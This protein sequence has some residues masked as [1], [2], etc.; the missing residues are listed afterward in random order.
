VP[1]EA[2]ENKKKK[3]KKKDVWCSHSNR[4]DRMLQLVLRHAFVDGVST[5]AV[6]EALLVRGSTRSTCFTHALLMLYSALLMLSSLCSLYSRAPVR[7]TS[8]FTQ[9]SHLL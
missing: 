2:L 6:D 3:E 7:F 8:C 4:L 9:S 1:G 5:R